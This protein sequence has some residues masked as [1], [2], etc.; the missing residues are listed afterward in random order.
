MPIPSF[1]FQ[2]WRSWGAAAVAVLVGLPCAAQNTGYPD[3]PVTLYVGFPA[4]GGSDGTARALAEELSKTLGQ[5][6]QVDNKPGATGNIATQQVLN[7]QADGYSLLFAAIHLATNPWLIGVKY[8]TAK[9]LTMV[10]QIA[11]VPV[12]LVASKQSGISSI[13]DIMAAAK[14]P[15]GLR[16]ASG[17]T[18][19]SSHL[20]QELLKRE[21]GI[22]LLH[23]PYKGASPALQ[24][25]VGGQTEIMFDFASGAM[26]AMIDSGKVVPIAVMQRDRIPNLPGVKS[27]ADWKLPASTHIRSWQGIAIKAGTPPAVVQRLHEAV[28]AATRSEGFRTKMAQMGSDVISSGKPEDF[29][30]FYLREL[31]RWGTL[32]KAAKITAE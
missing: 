18:G 21:L 24:D 22:P 23:I 15:E 1:P 6:V 4:G 17:G 32:I 29:Q 12:V 10:S 3:K 9:D 16:A 5:R 31:N 20:G 13:D 26:R 14:K 7:N 27:A 28:V 8:D 11:A 2:P 30:T 19:T 25:L